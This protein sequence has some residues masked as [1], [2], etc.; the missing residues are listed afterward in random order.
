MKVKELWNKGLRLLWRSG[1]DKARFFFS[2][3]DCRPVTE[4]RS[5]W[6]RGTKEKCKGHSPGFLYGQKVWLF[7]F[8]FSRLGKHASATRFV[9]FHLL[10]FVSQHQ[11]RYF[12]ALPTP[13]FV[14]DLSPLV[15]TIPWTESEVYFH[16]FCSFSCAE[17]W[18]LCSSVCFC[19][20]QFFQTA[21]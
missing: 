21:W 17:Y 10:G 2:L 1:R 8:L 14:L 5:M 12:L 6:V 16:S 4:D 3:E 9:L 13:L 20:M 7:G 19:R 18:A 11:L 15:A